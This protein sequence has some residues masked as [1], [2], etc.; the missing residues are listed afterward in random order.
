MTC[1]ELFFSAQS[2]LRNEEIERLA[3]PMHDV[4]WNISYQSRASAALSAGSDGESED[5]SSDSD[6]DE[7]WAFL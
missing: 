5:S 7:D 1:V 2:Q 3:P 6:S 4:E